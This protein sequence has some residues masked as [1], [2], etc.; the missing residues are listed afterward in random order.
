MNSVFMKYAGQ[1]ALWSGLLVAMII[2]AYYSVLK[3]RDQ[4]VNDQ[5]DLRDPSMNFREM[6]ERG[7]ISE[8]EYR[9]IKT[10]LGD[11]LRQ[12]PT[13]GTEPTEEGQ[14]GQSG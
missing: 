11:K 3:L 9:T 14:S 12:K 10:K 5:I 13:V 7:M 2:V 8:S 1:L 4:A 6:Y